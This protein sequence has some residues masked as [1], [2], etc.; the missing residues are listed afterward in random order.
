MDAPPADNPSLEEEDDGDN[1][2]LGV[3]ASGDHDDDAEGGAEWVRFRRYEEGN[4]LSDDE[5][6][7]DDDDNNDLREVLLNAPPPPLPPPPINATVSVPDNGGDL[8]NNS[9]GKQVID[10]I[11]D[12]VGK[13]VPIDDEKLNTMKVKEIKDQL[14]HRDIPSSN[15]IRTVLLD[16]LKAALKEKKPYYSLEQLKSLKKKKKKKTNVASVS[17]GLSGFPSTAYWKEL[18]GTTTA[19][20]PT[21][22]TFANARPP[23]VP[24]EDA[25]VPLNK[26]YNFEEVIDVPVFSAKTK[27]YEF[28]R[29]GEIK[30]DVATKEPIMKEI[31]RK[32]GAVNPVFIKKHKLTKM[33]RPHEFADAFIPFKSKY[34]SY[35]NTAGGFSFLNLTKWTNTKAMNADAGKDGS[36]YKDFV[37]FSVRELRSHF[38]LYVLQGLSPSPRVEYKFKPQTADPVNGNDYVYQSFGQ[39]MNRERRHKHFKAF[40]SFQD[41]TMKVPSRDSFPNWKVRP[42]LQWINHIGPLAWMLGMNI[43]VDEMTMRMKG[44]HRDRMTIKFKA[45]GDGFMTDA[46]C[47]EGYCYQHYMRNEPAPQKYLNMGFSPLHCRKVLC[48]GVARKGG[49]GVPE[50]VKQL[51]VTR[52]SEQLRVRGTVKAALLLGDDHVPC[53]VASSVYDTKPVHYLSMVSIRIEWIE[54]K[55]KAFNVDTNQWEEIKFLRMNFI[56]NYNFTMGHVDVAIALIFGYAIESGGGRWYSG[57]LVNELEGVEAKHLLTHYEFRKDIALYWINPQRTASPATATANSDCGRSAGTSMTSSRRKRPRLLFTS[58]NSVVSTLTVPT[59]VSTG[60][61][62][63]SSTVSDASLDV[64]GSLNCRLNRTLDHYPRPAAEMR[65]CALHMWCG[66]MRVESTLLYCKTCNVTV[67]SECYRLFH[68]EADLV[69]K[70]KEIENKLRRTFDWKKTKS[71][72]KMKGNKYHD[73]D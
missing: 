7:D 60:T 48:H 73:F 46:L 31:P 53:L 62:S 29:N 47:Q 27:V 12:S 13:H 70:K 26:K 34:S 11:N 38:G 49:R 45:E 30:I 42:L 52:R 50:C 10:L 57:A 15:G 14:K 17:T 72:K 65:R 44:V 19:V 69:E 56:N 16:Q 61:P 2:C 3:E 59:T 40:L 33:S 54:V 55:K 58:P 43:S 24:E 51:E 6:D 23:T 9:V 28:K 1:C 5:E 67:C 8:I 35:E 25:D 20:D 37:P 39:K 68:V 36:T 71:K 63:T 22:P 64:N 41:P 21:N 66:K 32:H 18:K 4:Q